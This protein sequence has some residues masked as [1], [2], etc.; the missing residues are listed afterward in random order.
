MINLYF[1]KTDPF[2]F[3]SSTL[4]SL[5]LSTLLCQDV[6]NMI[7]NIRHKCLKEIFKM[8][9]AY[10]L[11]INFYL[12]NDREIDLSITGSKD[13]KII[14][15]FCKQNNLI[16]TTLQVKTVIVYERRCYNCD[17]WNHNLAGCYCING[18]RIMKCDLCDEDL[19]CTYANCDHDNLDTNDI[20]VKC[21]N[22]NINVK[23]N[24]C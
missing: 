9:E 16:A 10:P 22:G 6:C 17:R 20:R 5:N 11:L 1:C 4:I 7:M 18:N 3:K 14:H 2:Y 15:Y 13:R 12:S 19:G 24:K 8:I 21:C 23:K